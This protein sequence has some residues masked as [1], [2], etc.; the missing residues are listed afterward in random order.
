MTENT[1]IAPKAGNLPCAGADGKA[2]RFPTGGPPK[3]SRNLTLDWILLGGR[4]RAGNRIHRG[5]RSGVGGRRPRFGASGWGMVNEL[6][7]DSMGTMK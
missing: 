7:I 3:E 1:A 6:L 5:A 2:G 4:K